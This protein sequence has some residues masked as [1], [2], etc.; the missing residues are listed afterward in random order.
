[1]TDRI[2]IRNIKGVKELDVT[3]E[4]PESNLLVVTGK[5]GVGKTTLVKAF[6][7]LDEPDIFVNTSSYK[8]IGDDSKV[9]FYISGYEPFAFTYDAKPGV[10]NSKDTLPSQGKIRAELPIPEGARFKHFDALFSQNE[11]L[12]SRNAA[13]DY[14]DASDLIEFLHTVYGGNKFESLKSVKIRKTSYYFI[15][16]S[17]DTYL[18]EDNLSSGE[19]FLIQIFRLISSGS[20]LVVIDELDVALDASAQVRLYQALIPLLDKHNSRLIVISHSLAFMSTVEDGSLYYL[21]ENNCQI[22]LEQRSFGYI[23]SDLYGFV[24]FDR[25]ILTEDPVLEG[26]IEFMVSYFSITPYYMHKT[27]GV[28]GVNQLRS[29]VEKNDSEC[30]FSSPENV[31]AISDADV[32]SQLTKGYSGRSDLFCSPIEDLELYIFKNRDSLLP[33][34]EKPTY[35]ERREAKPASK[36]YW[37]Y[38]TEDKNINSNSLYRL[39]AENNPDTVLEFAEKIQGFI[40]IG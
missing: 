11:E 15:P 19:Y 2:I 30:V 26:F 31:I 9:L 14:D 6:R 32:F 38:L 25:Y 3:F 1:M 27:I 28:G 7:L 20:E 36:R 5:N 13:K 21:E 12:E 40:K 16:Q 10:M 22:T 23:K 18:R 29:L 39:I 33:N 37:K 24:G 35:T 17:D 4:F 34:V 8:S